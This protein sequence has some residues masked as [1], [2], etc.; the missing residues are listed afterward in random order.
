VDRGSRRAQV[1]ADVSGAF[2]TAMIES[3]APSMRPDG[4]RPGYGTGGA[5]MTFR[6][7]SSWRRVCA[8]SPPS[9]PLKG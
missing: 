1:A 9:C 8:P 6:I 4:C 7:Q 5:G 3:A 2:H